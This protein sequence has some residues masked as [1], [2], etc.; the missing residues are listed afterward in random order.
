MTAYTVYSFLK[1]SICYD[2]KLDLLEQCV[3]I[4]SCERWKSNKALLHLSL[5]AELSKCGNVN[6]S[7]NADER[8]LKY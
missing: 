4:R 7:E 3:L 6:R 1:Q 2:I 8:H 5:K